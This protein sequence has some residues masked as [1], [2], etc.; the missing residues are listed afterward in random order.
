[1]KRIE[2]IYMLILS[3]C[4]NAI[5]MGQVGIN[6][7]NPDPSAVLHVESSNKGV[8]FPRVSLLSSTDASTI[9]NPANGLI[10]FNLSSAINGPG[11]YIN[12]G[13]NTA[14]QWERYEYYNI[15]SANLKVNK[16]IYNGPT[17]N[18]SQILKTT[19][20][21]WRLIKATATNYSIQARLLDAPI[22]PVSITGSQMLWS[23]SNQASAP[24]GISWTSSDWN[25]WKDLY[26]YNDNWDSV[27]F[28][29]VSSDPLHFYKLGSHVQLDT[30]NSLVLEI[31]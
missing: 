11:L 31:F 8:L 24:L 13:N 17:T 27:V 12:M 5:L 6:T 30:Y 22:A 7:S 21:E 28:L 14:P 2:I 19:S 1:M 26:I 23:S 18:A 9:L 29:N 4:N 10:V 20:F 25:V 15:S 16:L 3:I